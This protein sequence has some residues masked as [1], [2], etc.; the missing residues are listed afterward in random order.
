MTGLAPNARSRLVEES[1]TLV[2]SAE[3]A[4]LKAAGRDVVSLGAGEPDFPAPA[5]IAQA[6]IQAIEQHNYRYTETSGVPALREAGAAWLRDAFGLEYDAAEVM[7]TAGAKGALH[8]ALQTIVHPGDRVLVLAPYWVSYPALVTMAGGEAVIVPAMPERG[9]I[10]DAETIERAAAEHGAKGVIFNSPNNP[11]GAVAPREDVQALVDLCARRDMWIISDEIYATLLYDGAAQTSPASLPAG[12]ER[13]VVVNGFT[14]SH[15]MTGWRTSFMA[16][17]AE[18]IAAAGRIQSQLLGNPCTI[19]QAAMLEACRRPLPEDQA[20]RM[21]AFAERRA[22]LLERV[23]ALPGMSLA[24]PRGAFYALIDVRPICEQR[25]VDD[26]EVCQQLLQDHLL[27]LVP[28]SA[29]AAPGF[30]RASYAA[31]ME[32]LEKAVTRLQAWVET[33]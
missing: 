10:H 1:A 18:I 5:P 28:G 20:E 14:K 2:I 4:R 23:N 25:G 16:A 13:T 29:F 6:G 7:V 32:V 15:T 33:P 27:A 24:P 22:F 21:A 17:P 26:F 11:S 19:S 30:V 8:M 31:S 12:R 3:A 9:F